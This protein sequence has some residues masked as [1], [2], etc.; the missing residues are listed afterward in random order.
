MTSS[1]NLKE[2]PQVNSRE[3]TLNSV[4]N[5]ESPEIGIPYPKFIPFSLIEYADASRFEA[6]SD[7]DY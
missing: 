7:Q 1:T 6:L 5:S 3:E 4:D 2:S